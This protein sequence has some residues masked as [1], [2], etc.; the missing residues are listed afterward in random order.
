MKYILG[1]QKLLKG[2]LNRKI[3]RFVHGIKGKTQLEPK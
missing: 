1:V 3:T 2:F